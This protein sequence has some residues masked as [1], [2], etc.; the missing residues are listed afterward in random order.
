MKKSLLVLSITLLGVLLCSNVMGQ[1]T[2]AASNSLSLGMPEVLLLKSSASINLQLTTAIAGESV[3]SSISD[4]TARLKVSSVVATGKTRTLSAKVTTGPVP[5]GTTLKLQALSPTVGANYGGDM[6]TLV[7][8][9]VTLT[10]SSDATIISAIGSCFSGIAADDGYRL[11]YTWG[12][13][14]PG[15]NYGSVRATGT[16]V[17]ITVTLTLSAGL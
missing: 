17:P 14:N 11:K 12:L 9:D 15:T 13:D 8:S 6:G 2:Q 7:G 5:A 16:V 3:K 1:D 4:T 10:T